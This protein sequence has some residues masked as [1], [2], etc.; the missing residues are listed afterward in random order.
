NPDYVLGL[1][2]ILRSAASNNLSTAWRLMACD[3]VGTWLAC[4]KSQLQTPARDIGEF[5]RRSA[6]FSSI[7]NRFNLDYALRAQRELADLSELPKRYV[8]EL[9][10]F[11]EEYAAFVR[12]V[13]SWAEVVNNY[14]RQRFQPR[15][16]MKMLIN[17]HFE[18]V[19]SF[20][21]SET[22]IT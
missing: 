20:R 14:S 3:Y 21:R 18:R 11:R 5:M 10:K 17:S 13:E 4:Y 15:E 19:A 7:V 2:H 1:F 8:E 16:W 9:E 12:D 6:E 22:A